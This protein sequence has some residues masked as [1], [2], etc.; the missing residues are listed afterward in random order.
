MRKLLSK[1]R[2]DVFT[3][4]SLARQIVT[5]NRRAKI[6]EMLESFEILCQWRDFYKE[7]KEKEDGSP[8]ELFDAKMNSTL[9]WRLTSIFISEKQRDLRM[10]RN[11]VLAFLPQRPE[12]TNIWFLTGTRLFRDRM[13]KTL[14]LYA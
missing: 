9:R 3:A 7:K 11:G 12:R 6:G 10:R 1:A 8:E 14:L 13:R 4:L 5:G 2:T